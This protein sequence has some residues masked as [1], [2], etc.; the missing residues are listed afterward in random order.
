M[1]K[2]F[3][4]LNVLVNNMALIKKKIWPEYF[5]NVFSGKKKFKL[6]LNDFEVVEKNKKAEKRGKFKN[7]IILEES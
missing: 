5:N 4:D 7:K 1:V 3:Q 2:K 6:R